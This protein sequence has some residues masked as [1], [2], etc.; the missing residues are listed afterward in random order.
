MTQEQIYKIVHCP[1]FVNCP[2]IKN[3]TCTVYGYEFN[4]VDLRYLT[5]CPEYEWRYKK[6]V[7]KDEYNRRPYLEWDLGRH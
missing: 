1:I 2:Y 4:T 5:H 6:L 3:G 7:H